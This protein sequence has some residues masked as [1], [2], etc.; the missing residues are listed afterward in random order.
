M[1]ANIIVV[2]C[3]LFVVRKYLGG[4]ADN[5]QRATDYDPKEKPP[6]FSRGF[7]DLGIGKAVIPI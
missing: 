2:S 5:G 4:T 6:N 7:S 1:G 3:S